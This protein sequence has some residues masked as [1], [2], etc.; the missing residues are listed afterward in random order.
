[1]SKPE[2]RL[3]SP[4]KSNHFTLFY[5]EHEIYDLQII[6]IISNSCSLKMIGQYIFKN[7][8]F[9]IQV[10]YSTLTQKFGPDID[11]IYYIIGYLYVLCLTII[12]IMLR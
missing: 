8:K 4:I 3:L 7:D 5:V 12:F 11:E 6:N 2:F 9:K 10:I 1:M